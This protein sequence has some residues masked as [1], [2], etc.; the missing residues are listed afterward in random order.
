MLGWP[1]LALLVLGVGIGLR[2][3]CHRLVFFDRLLMAFSLAYL[4]VHLATT[5]PPWDRY[6]LPLVPPLALVLGHGLASLWGTLGRFRLDWR[7]SARSLLLSERLRPWLVAALAIT[8]A[9]T[10][11]LAS[12]SSIP[13][14][15]AT[16]YDSAAPLSDYVRET[17]PPGTI[18]YH[19]WLGWHY[20]Y[21]LSG[22]SVDLRYWEDGADLVAKAAAEPQQR[23]LIAFPAGRDQRDARNLLAAAG[24]SLQPE[25]TV[26][27]RDGALS[28]TLFRIVPLDDPS[29]LSNVA[30]ASRDDG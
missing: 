28:A 11:W 10:L 27:H 18:L 7:L 6:A 29:S 20:G 23:Q 9:F 30:G 2:R 16:A 12:F 24:L 25:L 22:A 1:L 4:L 3:G 17:Q 19:H 15:D 8:G 26:Y 21:Y 5:M 14:G 13:V